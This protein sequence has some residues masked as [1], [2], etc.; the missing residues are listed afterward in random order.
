LIVG[1]AAVFLPLLAVAG[2]PPTGRPELLV[3][4]EIRW[5]FGVS[6]WDLVGALPLPLESVKDRVGDGDYRWVNRGGVDLL[7]VNPAAAGSAFGLPRAKALY[8]PLPEQLKDPASFASGLKALLAARAK[9]RVAEGDLLA[10]PEPRAAG[11]CALVLKL[12]DHP[13]AV[14]VLNFGRDEAAEE[15]DLGPAGRP[16]GEWTNALTGAAGPAGG[17]RL[18]VRVPGLGWAVFVLVPAK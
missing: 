18:A 7:G 14:V 5:L 1:P 16:A 2:P 17:G 8:G 4:A 10:A 13:L 6:G 15:I 12:P 9:Y 3:N 11:L